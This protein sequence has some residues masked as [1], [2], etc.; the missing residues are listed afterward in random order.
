MTLIAF[1]MAIVVVTVS[2]MQVPGIGIVFPF[3]A[4]ATLSFVFGM[5]TW[6]VTANLREIDGRLDELAKFVPLSET[7]QVG[8][9]LRTPSGDLKHLRWSIWFPR[10]FLIAS[11]L[12]LLAGLSFAV[13]GRFIRDDEEISGE[14]KPVGDVDTYSLRGKAEDALLIVA[15]ERGNSCRFNLQVDVYEP[16]PSEKSIA[17]GS[18]DQCAAIVQVILPYDGS[19]TIVVRETSSGSVPYTL[20]IVNVAGGSGPWWR[21]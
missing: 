18:A 10:L 5:L 4:L 8:H 11:I 9:H 2:L 14:I 3:L 13:Y 6:R 7:Q 15:T 12:L 17:Q 1:Y 19:Y 16:L 21:Y 20:E